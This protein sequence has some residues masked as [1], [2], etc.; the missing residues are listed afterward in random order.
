MT[1]RLETQKPDSALTLAAAISR[2]EVTPGGA[3]AGRNDARGLTMRHAVSAAA[4]V[5]SASCI[6]EGGFAQRFAAGRN[7][8]AVQTGGDKMEHRNLDMWVT[9]NGR[10]R[11]E[12][13]PNS[14]HHEARV[15]SES[16]YRGRYGLRGMRIEYW[17]D[18]GYIADDSFVREN[19]QHH[20]GMT[21]HRQ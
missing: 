11:H 4:L 9:G 8:S 16:A 7:T 20:G 14:G 12:L 19:E 18:T 5:A 15:T 3:R 17:D 1:S 21:F 6:P 2:H 10:I 13:L